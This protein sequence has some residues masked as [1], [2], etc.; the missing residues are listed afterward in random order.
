[1]DC[2]DVCG[3]GYLSNAKF[4]RYALLPLFLGLS[5]KVFQYRSQELFGFSGNQ[6]YSTQSWA[7][8]FCNCR[9]F[10]DF[11]FDDV[12]RCNIVYLPY[13]HTV[14]NVYRHID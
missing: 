11:Y 12:I 3:C 9:V 6:N 14:D 7:K 8:D 1:M 4:A 10:D 13:L 5:V 2:I